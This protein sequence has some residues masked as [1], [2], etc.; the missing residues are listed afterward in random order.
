M[1]ADVSAEQVTPPMISVSERF[2]PDL[3]VFEAMNTG[4]G[5]AASVLEVPAAFAIGL[6]PA[7]YNMLHRATIGYQQA[8]WL[9]RGLSP[10]TTALL[11]SALLSPVPPSLARDE[12]GLSVPSHPD[13][14]RR[15]QRPRRGR[16]EWL[17]APP[18]RPRVYVTWAPSPSAPSRCCDAR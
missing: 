3:V 7:A 1:F 18:E 5:V 13:P 8:T 4:A 9:Q 2:R 14:H 11:A 15:L 12:A 16:P 10:P 6:T 17:T